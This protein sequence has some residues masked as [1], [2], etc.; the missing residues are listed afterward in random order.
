MRFLRTIRCD[1]CGETIQV[2]VMG[3]YHVQCG[4]CGKLNSKRLPFT[5]GNRAG[6]LKA[7]ED[8]RAFEEKAR[9]L[10]QKAQEEAPT[11]PRVSLKL[12]VGPPKPEPKVEVK[13][14]PRVEAEVEPFPEWSPKMLKAD[15]LEIAE[16]LGL[17]V[18]SKDKKAK[19]VEALE[20]AQSA[21]ESGLH[22]VAS[23]LPHRS[24]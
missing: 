2:P 20:A 18:S 6:V 8:R 16:G 22:R 23:H 24:V 1:Q 13:T 11:E 12:R 5:P 7:R 19:I 17:D 10:H 3:S 14:K 4:E 15:L 9:A 21:H